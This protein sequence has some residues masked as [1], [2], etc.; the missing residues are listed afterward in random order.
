MQ[1]TKL[2]RRAAASR[3]AAVSIAAAV[4]VTLGGT[5]AVAA[6][7]ITSADIKDGSIHGA[8]LASSSVGSSKIV[9]GSVGS[10]DLGPNSVGSSEISAA[11][12]NQ[13][14][15]AGLTGGPNWSV[16]DR[17][18][19]DSGAAHL[20]LGPN[21][22]PLGAADQPL[23]VVDPPLGIGSLGLRT[24]SNGDRAAFGNEV[25][26][27]G[28]RVSSLTTLGFSV[29][30]TTENNQRGPNMP[31][32]FLEIDP[33]L[34]GAPNVDVAHMIYTP[35]N[36]QAD[37]WTA[38]DATDNTQGTTWVLTGPAGTLIGCAPGGGGCTWD[39][40]Q[41]RLEDEDNIPARIY[42]LLITKGPDRAFSGAVDALRVRD[43]V[44]DFEPLGVSAQ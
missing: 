2:Y 12:L 24:G 25:A 20:R 14:Q 42:T 9:N 1:T 8:D 41:N 36:G 34:S 17:I 33:N 10:E 27:H 5:G 23:V 32:I 26:F 21:S 29:F 19:L 18:V 39:Q 44:Y 30:T 37:R 38:F 40:I 11:L 7:L 4:V 15:Q 43:R 6:G 3:V 22:N 28:D 35:A 31:S 13:I 16:V